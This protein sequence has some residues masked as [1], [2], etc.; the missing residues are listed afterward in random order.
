[1]CGIYG[2][3]GRDPEIDPD[4]ALLRAVAAAARRGPH[5]WG[6]A[7]PFERVASL[8]RFSP[9]LD[10]PTVDHWIIG[11][12]RLATVGDPNDIDALQPVKQEGHVLAHNGNIR[13][14][15]DLSSQAR[16]DSYAVLDLYARMRNTTGIPNITGLPPEIVLKTILAHAD[17]D[18]H[19]MILRDADGTWMLTRHHLPLYLLE[20]ASGAYVS[21]V[22]FHQDAVLI[23]EHQ[24]THL[25]EH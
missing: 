24:I 8:G 2:Y 6:W 9:D 10:L 13:N 5:G 20:A 7:T 3:L 14:W 19:A 25:Q 21:S 1:M 11:H 15:R 12:S 18:A 22:C 23:P 17:H 16:T 4:P